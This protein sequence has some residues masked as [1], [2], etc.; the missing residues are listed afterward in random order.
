MIDS[1]YVLYENG[2]KYFPDYESAW[3][4]HYKSRIKRVNYCFTPTMQLCKRVSD[5]ERIARV[6]FNK[7]VGL[8]YYDVISDS[9]FKQIKLIGEC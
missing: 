2:G 5:L 8:D 3:K 1:I 9:G 4:N 7:S 6:Y